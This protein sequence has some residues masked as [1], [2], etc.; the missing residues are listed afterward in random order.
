MED[1][2]PTKQSRYI[3]NWLAAIDKLSRDVMLMP[4]F[5]LLFRVYLGATGVT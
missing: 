5:T 4:G 1:Q 3:W 2:S